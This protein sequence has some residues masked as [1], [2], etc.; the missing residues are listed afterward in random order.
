MARTGRLFWIQLESFP[1]YFSEIDEAIK[2]HKK[3]DYEQCKKVRRLVDKPAKDAAKLPRA[4]K[5]LSMAKEIYDE[6]NDQLKAEL[7]QLI[8]LRVPFYDPSFE[9]LVKIQLRFCTEGTRDWHR[10][11]S[12][13]T[14]RPETSMPMGCWTARLMICW[15]KCKV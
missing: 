12:T 4:E 10:S 15:H 3:I 8:A 9:A 2:T 13:W 6:L 1:T 14:Q 5:E 11:N 7:P